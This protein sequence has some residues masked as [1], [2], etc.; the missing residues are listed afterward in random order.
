LRFTEFIAKEIGMMTTGTMTKRNALFNLAGSGIVCLLLVGVGQATV[1]RG[2]VSINGSDSNPCSAAQPCRSFNQALT[3]VEPGGEIVVQNSGGYSSGF[4]I[5]QSVTI[6]AAG[7]NASVISTSTGDL[8]TISAG[9]TDRVVLR[10]ISFHGAG[11][12][13]N[14]AINVA[15]AGSVYIE[16]CSVAE[17]GG[18]GVRM[19]AGNLF[20]TATDLRAC[21][22]SGIGVSSTGATPADLVASDSRFTECGNGVLLQTTGTG[23]ATASLSNCAASLCQTNGFFAG[24]G[25]SANARMSLT[26]CRAF[27]N[28]TGVRAVTTQTGGATISLANCV[29]T[30]NS[31]GITQ[32]N[33]GTGLA[34]LVG[35][36][37]GTNLITGN[38]SDGVTFVSATLQ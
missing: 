32:N 27:A 30:D 14:N 9:P 24:S 23:A 5:T 16:H 31:I 21:L 3:V 28:F 29:V 8:C 38:G 6:D 22:G 11:G 12:L 35:T 34:A 25:S 7:F 17:F 15:Q 13:G 19:G 2:F 37:Q 18:D 33:F 4:T 1:P 36:S 20:V 26:K 10:G